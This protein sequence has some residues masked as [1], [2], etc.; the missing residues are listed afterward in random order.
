MVQNEAFPPG[1]DEEG[2]VASVEDVFEHWRDKLEDQI[3]WNS[4]IKRAIAE[5]PTDPMIL[6]TVYIDG[7]LDTLGSFLQRDETEVSVIIGY[8]RGDLL[9]HVKSLLN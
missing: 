3:N 7:L 6:L 1:E 5:N 4:I 9:E 8:I 2:W